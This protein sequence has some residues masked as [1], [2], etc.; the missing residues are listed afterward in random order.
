MGGSEDFDAS[1]S[2][3]PAFGTELQDRSALR[4][5]GAHF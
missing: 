2:I 3:M 5:K 4:L 1:L